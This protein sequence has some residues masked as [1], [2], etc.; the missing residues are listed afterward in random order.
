VQLDARLEGLDAVEQEP[1]L[2]TFLVG[3]QQAGTASAV[4]SALR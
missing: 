1:E 3:A 4:F 2:G